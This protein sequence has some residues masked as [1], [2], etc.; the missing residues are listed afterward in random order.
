MTI[1]IFL[2]DELKC[3]VID[4]NAIFKLEMNKFQKDV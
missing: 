2:G 3:N 4:M 1:R